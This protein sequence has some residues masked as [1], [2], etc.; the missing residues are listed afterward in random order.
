MM[1]ANLT[2][3][4]SVAAAISPSRRHMTL[5]RTAA[6][7]AASVSLKP[8]TCCRSNAVSTTRT[9]TSD[10]V[11]RRFSAALPNRMMDRRCPPRWVST[12]A[13]NKVSVRATASGRSLAASRSGA[14]MSTCGDCSVFVADSERRGSLSFVHHDLPVLHHPLHAFD[15]VLDV[16]QRLA[17]YSDDVGVETPGDF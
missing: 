3:K 2:L 17:F 1:S 13:T 7:A 10:V 12:A 14:V 9:L 15:R 4:A 11:R 8:S 16:L 6:V 5:R